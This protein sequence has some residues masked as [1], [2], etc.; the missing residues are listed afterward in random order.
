M[1][2]QCSGYRLVPLSCAWSC[3]SR[4]DGPQGG[5][6]HHNTSACL[7]FVPSVIHRPWQFPHESNTSP[8]SHRVAKVVIETEGTTEFTKSAKELGANGREGSK[9]C[10]HAK[11]GRA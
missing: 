2:D 6:T 10:C 3:T 7:C 9:T 4:G 5:A 8:P 11:K 1:T